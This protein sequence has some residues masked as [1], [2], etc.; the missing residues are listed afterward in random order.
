M[1][2]GEAA[3]FASGYNEWQSLWGWRRPRLDRRSSRPAG[4]MLAV[5]RAMSCQ[6]PA[7]WVSGAVVG[8]IEK[9]DG[10]T[11]VDWN[12]VI[13]VAIALGILGFWLLWKLDL[14]QPVIDLQAR[15]EAY[16]AQ[17]VQLAAEEY[18]RSLD[19]RLDSL[20]DIVGILDSVGQR[21]QQT[22]LSH[23]ELQRT[24]L[25]WGGY[26]GTMLQ[27]QF[28]GQWAVDSLLA[29]IQTYPLRWA[30]REA[31]PVIWCLRRIRRGEKFDLV[32]TVRQLSEELNR[33]GKA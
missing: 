23:K 20:E 27:R 25:V 5:R 10:W 6:L 26:L 29:G 21:H 28:G 32:G 19:Y 13:V 8:G 33:A 18:Q 15:M 17:A 4:A 7:W 11:M 3:T 2:L 30:E 12:L 22:P 24:I 9:R 31:I 14:G 16:A 1:N